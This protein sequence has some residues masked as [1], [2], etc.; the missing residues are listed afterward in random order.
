MNFSERY[1]KARTDVIA[2]L[3]KTL[4]AIKPEQIERL[5][6]EIQKADQV[7]FVGVGRVMMALECV[8]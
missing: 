6:N 2:E 5:Y 8:C 3:D 7:F 1:L 4:A